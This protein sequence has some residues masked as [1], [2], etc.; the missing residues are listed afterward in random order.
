MRILCFRK[1][2]PSLRH[3]S[4]C[5]QQSC[6]VK[7]KAKI[8]I[9]AFAALACLASCSTPWQKY[10]IPHKEPSKSA[11]NDVTLTFQRFES[12]NNDFAVIR[13]TNNSR[14]DLIWFGEAHTPFWFIEKRGLFKWQA[15][16]LGSWC[17]TGAGHHLLA[18][19]QSFEFRVRLAEY[20]KGQFQVG[21]DYHLPSRDQNLVSW[22]S[23]FR[24]R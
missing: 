2:E 20:G 7:L 10:A 18:V 15:V 23:P 9:V 12:Q 3:L 14:R 22:S 24:R 1:K 4:I 11:E 5:Y 17:G 16:S 19:G 6:T 13:F 21:V 8:S